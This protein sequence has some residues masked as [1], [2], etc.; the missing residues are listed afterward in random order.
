MRMG[1]DRVSRKITTLSSNIIANVSFNMTNISTENRN[2]VWDIWNDAA[3]ANGLARTFLWDG[4]DE[5]DKTLLRSYVVQF[6]SAIPSDIGPTLDG[7]PSINLRIV[8]K[9]A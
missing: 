1:A 7:L 4:F 2:T 5:E 8:G 6:N 9:P 3:K